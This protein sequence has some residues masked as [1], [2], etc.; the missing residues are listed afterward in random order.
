MAAQNQTQTLHN[1]SWRDQNCHTI[2]VCAYSEKH[3]RKCIRKLFTYINSI[4][5]RVLVVRA[6]QKQVELELR[7]IK[8]QI[9][10]REHQDRYHPDHQGQFR[11]QGPVYTQEERAAHK[12]SMV[13]LE[14]RLTLCYKELRELE[15]SIPAN[16]I[17]G[18]FADSAV[19]FTAV[20]ADREKEGGLEDFINHN[21]PTT[22]KPVLPVQLISFCYE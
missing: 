13:P 12:E 20:R 8:K 5:P 10:Q 4:R 6:T 7:E 16:C 19:D 9:Q 18:P 11:R 22:I 14:Q 2:S 3:A 1:F 21:P 15:E 17:Q